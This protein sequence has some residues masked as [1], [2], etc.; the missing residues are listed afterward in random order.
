MKIL[1]LSKSIQVTAL[2]GLVSALSLG[3]ASSALAETVGPVIVSPNGGRV[4]TVP[5]YYSG[6]VTVSGSANSSNVKFVLVRSAN[7][8]FDPDDR[9]RI[10]EKIGSSFYASFARYSYPQVFPGYFKVCARNL[11][12]TGVAITL[13]ITGN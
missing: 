3:A 10:A 9:D 8:Y 2:A 12:T 13:S 1:N 11:D 4:C 6:S 7:G 5:T